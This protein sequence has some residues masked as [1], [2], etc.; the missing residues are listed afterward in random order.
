MKTNNIH[1]TYY[2]CHKTSDYI[3]ESRRFCEAQDNCSNCTPYL[4]NNRQ[5]PYSQ[6]VNATF[7]IEKH[8][9]F[10]QFWSDMHPIIDNKEQKK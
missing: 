7:D 4:C 9:K 1:L 8:I 5:C 6:L 10:L 2:D 3:H